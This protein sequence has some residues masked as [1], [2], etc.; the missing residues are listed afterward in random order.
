MRRVESDGRQHRQQLGLKKMLEPGINLRCP[1]RTTQK[2]NAC[3]FQPRHH[4][5][6]EGGVLLFHQRMC[7]FGDGRKQLAG[8]K[9]VG[10]V[11]LTAS[12]HHL[13]DAGDAY[14]EKLIEIGGGDAQE[15]QAFQQRN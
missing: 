7:F 15:T 8:R 3:V 12:L 9:A 1:C 5:V 4:H 2:P 10:R 14:L 11:Q 6:V 13:L